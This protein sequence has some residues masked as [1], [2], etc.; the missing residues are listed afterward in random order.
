MIRRL[1]TR[2]AARMMDRGWL[3]EMRAREVASL[4]AVPPAQ[5]PSWVERSVFPEKRGQR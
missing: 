3:R 5:R 2:I 1:L 4:R